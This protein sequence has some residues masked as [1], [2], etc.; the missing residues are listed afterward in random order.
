MTKAILFLT[1][2]SVLSVQFVFAGTRIA[3]VSG[4]RQLGIAGYPLSEDFVVQVVSSDNK[5]TAK[6]P[7]VF[8]VISQIPNSLCSSDRVEST[9][10][11]VLSITDFSGYARTRL[12]V[13]YPF[14]GE[15]LVSALTRETLGNPAVFSVN[16]HSKHWGILIVFGLFGGLGLFLFGLVYLNSAL[17]KAAAYK[18]REVL[19]TLTGSKI[20][21]IGTGF[22]VTLFN[23]SSSATTLL[24]VSLVG[25]GLL[26]FYQTMAVTM[27]AEIGSTATTQ[28]LA[29]RLSDYAVFFAGM[30]FYISFFAQSKKWKRAGD[31]VLGFGI[32]FLGI[33]I[34]SDI[35]TPLRDYGPFMQAMKS[36]GNPIYGIL[37]GLVFTMLVHSSGATSGVVI[38]LALAGAINLE[39]AVPLNL[40]AQIGTCFTA[41]LGS[42]GRGREGKRVALWHVFHQTAG[43]LLVLPFLTLIKFGGEPS[44]IYFSKWFTSTFFGTSD[45]IRQIAMAHTLSSVFNTLIF[46][47]FLPV[48]SKML[49]KILPRRE[50]EKPFGP[51]YID[52][53]FLST[54]SLAIEQARK[55]VLREAEIIVEMMNGTLKVFDAQDMKLCETVSLKD[56]RVDVLHNAVVP[57]LTKIPQGYLTEEQSF[58]ETRLLYITAEFEA[59]GDIIDKNIMPLAR[60]KIE[61]NMWFSDEGWEDVV[62]LHKRVSENLEQV[63]NA[64]RNNDLELARLVSSNEAEISRY[65]SELRKKHISRLHSGL[66][67]SLETSSV[68]LDLIDQFKRINSHIATIS[69]TL[70]GQI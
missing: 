67:E 63:I 35:L 48:I 2:M 25:A 61:N 12:N 9:L 20:R 6:V 42:I 21:G 46:L 51:I 39:Q 55:E 5:G 57:Y 16:V 17:Q 65:E 19:I 10:T 60:K 64:L 26:T 41:V 44:W 24:E 43:V 47:P 28:L 8:S 62:D 40:G 1:M 58:M 27:G 68:H 45:L 18:L 32:L 36:I 33:K 54:P 50:E 56:I 38:A 37:V 4:D 22:F 7:V 23:Q 70:L 52:E 34:M 3:K 66:Q 49:Y 11:S 69:N 14:A 13:A 15:I 30:G 59:I 29:F 53:V 31:A